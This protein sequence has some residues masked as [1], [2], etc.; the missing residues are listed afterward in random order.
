MWSCV[1]VWSCVCGRVTTEPAGFVDHIH[2]YRTCL[3]RRC[4]TVGLQVI[5][6]GNL[7][8]G[9]QLGLQIETVSSQHLVAPPIRV[10]T[11]VAAV[12]GAASLRGPNT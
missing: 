6:G 1:C 2:T 11:L 9:G 4:V 5:L 10:H 12:V 8:P 3:A 7:R